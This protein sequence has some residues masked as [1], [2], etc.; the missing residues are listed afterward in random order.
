MQARA[1]IA[2]G[3]TR[4]RSSYIPKHEL[5]TVGVEVELGVLFVTFPAAAV[6]LGMQRDIP[7]VD[8]SPT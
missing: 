6:V 5:A 4:W 3:S 7:P 8:A 2:T 1:N